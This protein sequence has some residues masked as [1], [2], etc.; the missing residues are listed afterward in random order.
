MPSIA[1][2]YALMLLA[3]TFNVGI[4]LAIVLGL[5]IGRFS[6][7]TAQDALGGGKARTAV[8]LCH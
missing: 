1:L 2:Q 3:M 7:L 8:E 4:L 6:A 5:A